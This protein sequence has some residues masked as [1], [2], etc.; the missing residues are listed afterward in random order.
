MEYIAIRFVAEELG[1]SKDQ[2]LRSVKKSADKLGWQPEYRKR[3]AVYLSHAG[4]DTLI[5]NYEP[6]NFRRNET[7]NTAAKKGFDYFLLSSFTLK[8][9][10][11][12]SKLDTRIT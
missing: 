11:I 12:G 5:E 8:T 10:Q 2:T 7:D 3:N 6:R 4:A 1:T 9:C